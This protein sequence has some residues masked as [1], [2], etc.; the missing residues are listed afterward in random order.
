MHDLDLLLLERSPPDPPPPRRGSRKRD[1]STA[2]VDEP[3]PDA[4]KRCSD[5]PDAS[6]GRLADGSWGSLAAAITAENLSSSAQIRPETSSPEAALI[7]SDSQST[8][9]EKPKKKKR[10]L[11][12]KN[13][14]GWVSPAFSKNVDRSW[15]E[16]DSPPK[17]F[18]VARYVPQ[19]GDTI[20]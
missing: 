10:E 7:E 15:L 2:A 12:P 9:L 14:G 11:V 18:D 13:V 20:V 4:K 19:I 17:K 5:S 1:S 16:S 3:E 8:T 6:K